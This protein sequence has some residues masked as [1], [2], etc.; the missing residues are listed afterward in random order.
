MESCPKSGGMALLNLSGSPVHAGSS[1]MLSWEYLALG[2]AENLQGLEG[3]Q[4]P[5]HPITLAA[6]FCG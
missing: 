6:P 4:T 5:P 3:A 1:G 2:I